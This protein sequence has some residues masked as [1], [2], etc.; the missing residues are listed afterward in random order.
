MLYKQLIGFLQEK[1]K[2]TLWI[3]FPMHHFFTTEKQKSLLLKNIY[4][5]CND[6]EYFHFISQV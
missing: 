3:T 5:E 4:L 2:A 6:S 1:K